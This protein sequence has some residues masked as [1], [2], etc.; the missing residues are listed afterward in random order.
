MKLVV[1]EEV[2]EW[3]QNFIKNNGVWNIFIYNI[4]DFR[5]FFIWRYVFFNFLS[6]MK[7]I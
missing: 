6:Q 2:D 5:D 3:I 4:F 1:S 7:D